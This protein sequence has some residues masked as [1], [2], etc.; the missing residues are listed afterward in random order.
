MVRAAYRFCKQQRADYISLHDPGPLAS[1]LRW[2]SARFGPIRNIAGFRQAAPEPPWWIYVCD[3]ARPR[4]HYFVSY[5]ASGVG[6]ALSGSEALRRALGEA[7]ERY[8]GYSSFASAPREVMKA[9][10]CLLHGTFP[11]C[12]PDE[13]CSQYFKSVPASLPLNHAPMERLAD[14]EKVWVPV[15]YVHLSPEL[16]EGEPLITSPISTGM[17]FHTELHRA[18]WSGLCEI[19]ERDAIMMFWWRQQC[20]PRIRTDH[21]SLPAA[22][23]ERVARA[24]CSGLAVHLFDMSTDFRVPAVFC[25]LQGRHYPFYV[26][27]ASCNSDP[28]VA[29]TKALDETVAVRFAL[30]S[31]TPTIPSWEQFDWVT[32]LEHHAELY[33]AWPDSPALQFLFASKHQNLSFQEFASR[34]WWPDVRSMKELRSL[35]VELERMQLTALWSDLTLD[36]ARDFGYCVRVVVPQ[37]IPLSASHSSR[38]LGTKRLVEAAGIGIAAAARFNP[39]PHPFA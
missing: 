10:D 17:A 6:A 30:A 2:V 12:A 32:T 33:A 34:D 21:G 35:A 22:L 28:L 26:G 7:V 13:P 11:T 19:A 25:V 31:R 8:T 9:G 27:S 15:P 37:M 29:C 5:P 38:W 23:A 4:G 14:G 18:I 1:V 24:E 39:Y 16:D 20:L 3:L 36:D